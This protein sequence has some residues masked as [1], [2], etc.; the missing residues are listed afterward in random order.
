MRTRAGEPRGVS[1]AVRDL[2]LVIGMGRSG[3]S[4]L[5]RILSLCGCALP[6]RVLSPNFANPSGYW[7]SERAV[8]INDAFLE[9]HGSSWYDGTLALQSGLAGAAKRGEFVA[10]IATHLKADFEGGGPLVL[11]DPRITGL[12]PYWTA[13]ARELRMPVKVVHVF[14]DPA[15]VAASLYVRDGLIADHSFAL[16]LKYNLIGERDARSFPRVVVSYDDLMRNWEPVVSRCIDQLDIRAAVDDAARHAVAGFLSP[17][18][19]HHAGGTPEPA[20]VAPVLAERSRQTNDLLHSA[21]R[22]QVRTTE[23]DAVRTAYAASGVALDFGLVHRLR[24]A[25]AP[26]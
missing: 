15:E 21:V 24:E 7:E 13:A 2:V 14:R 6:L 17:A 8:Q 10:N 3:T 19:R 1:A 5:T 25:V 9:A 18:L 22:G 12:L 26:A 4:A 16:W 11:K 20:G 23:F